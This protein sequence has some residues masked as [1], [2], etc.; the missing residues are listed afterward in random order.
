M[1]YPTTPSNKPDDHTRM[2]MRLSQCSFALDNASEWAYTI[3]LPLVAAE[4]SKVSADCADAG[5]EARRVAQSLREEDH[6]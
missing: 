6:Q 2:A 3:G 5:I 1:D 4:L